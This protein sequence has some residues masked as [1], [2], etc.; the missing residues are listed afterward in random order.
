MAEPGVLLTEFHGPQTWS[1]IRKT[2]NINRGIKVTILRT[3][4]LIDVFC[5]YFTTNDPIFM[6]F[7]CVFFVLMSPIE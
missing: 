2:E 3:K 6:D 5:S 1:R 4:F 7:F